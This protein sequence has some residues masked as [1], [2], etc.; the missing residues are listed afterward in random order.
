[1]EIENEYKYKEQFYK[2]F[3]DLKLE[4]VNIGCWEVYDYVVELERQFNKLV[5]DLTSKNFWTN[6]PRILG[7]DSK[8]L[9]VEEILS[10]NVDLKEQGFDWIELIEKDYKTINHENSGR[11]LNEPRANSIIFYIE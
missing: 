2:R 11:K 9:L 4:L 8:L 10:F 1:M 6:I 3:M 7:I 5:L